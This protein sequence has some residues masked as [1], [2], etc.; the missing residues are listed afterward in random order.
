MGESLIVPDRNGRGADVVLGVAKPADYLANPA[1]NA[2]SCL[3]T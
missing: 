3:A 1:T 2:G